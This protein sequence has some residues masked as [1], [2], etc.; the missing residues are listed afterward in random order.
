MRF[1]RMGANSI[2]EQRLGQGIRF[3]REFE[4]PNFCI[5]TMHVTKP[6]MIKVQIWKPY[7]TV[8]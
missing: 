8:I 3:T 6:N 2:D 5:V 4:P 7:V 1:S